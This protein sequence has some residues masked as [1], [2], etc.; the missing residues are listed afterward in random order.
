MMMNRKTSINFE[1]VTCLI[2]GASGGIGSAFAQAMD[3]KGARLILAGRSQKKL[4]HLCRALS[5][6]HQLLEADIS[7]EDGRQAVIE[8]IISN[9]SINLI[10][11]AAGSSSFG[12][13]TSQTSA[14]IEHAIQ[15]NLVA[16]ILI[17]QA[18]LPSLLLRESVTLVNVGSAFGSIGYAGFSSYC[19][20]KFGLYGFTESLQRELSGSRI[21]IKYFAPRATRTRFNSRSVDELNHALGNCIDSPE[22]VA[23]A[24][25]KMLQQ[26]KQRV[27]VGWPEK[28]FCRLNGLLPELVDSALMKKRNIIIHY[29][30]QQSMEVASP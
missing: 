20:S 25:V 9:K 5:S 10:V 6:R 7:G 1:E 19:A 16:P 28:I 29:A 12:L 22:E 30:K 3:R 13:I 14:G 26:D 17:I 4:E 23:G 24:L 2:T 21:K 8:Q 27:I 11:Q 15:L 18:V